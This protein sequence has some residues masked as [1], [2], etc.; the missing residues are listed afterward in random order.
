MRHNCF[1]VDVIDYR[2]SGGRE[3]ELERRLRR[4]PWPILR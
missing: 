4:Y 2:L 3:A 1:I